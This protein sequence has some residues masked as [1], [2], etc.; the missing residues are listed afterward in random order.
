M[1]RLRYEIERELSKGVWGSV[2]EVTNACGNNILKNWDPYHEVK[3][4]TKTRL[5]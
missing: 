5:A 1:I 2:L 3:F 4:V